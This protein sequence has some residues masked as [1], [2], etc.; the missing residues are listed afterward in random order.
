MWLWTNPGIDLCGRLK[1]RLMGLPG[2]FGSGHAFSTPMF[3]FMNRDHAAFVMELYSSRLLYRQ[4]S[5]PRMPR[6]DPVSTELTNNST[7][8]LPELSDTVAFGQG[9]VW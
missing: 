4:S 1:W 7:G 3:L 2:R 5:G 9:G 8:L 6:S